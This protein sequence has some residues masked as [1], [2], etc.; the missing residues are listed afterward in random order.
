MLPCMFHGQLGSGHK[1]VT[2]SGRSDSD[3]D[4]QVRQVRQRHIQ[5][6][7]PSQAGQTATWM[8]KSGRSDSDMSSTYDQV[9]QIRQRHV[10][11]ARP[12]QAGRQRHVQHVRPSQAGQTAT[13]PAR[14]TKSGRSDSDMSCM[15]DQVRQV[16]RRHVQHVRPSQAGH[17]ATCPART[18][19]THKHCQ[20]M[21]EIEGRQGGGELPQK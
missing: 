4:D 18:T 1:S 6:V 7:R 12:S 13:C 9:R 16:R 11:H 8:T 3:I 5:Y 19:C 20:S 15:Y 21:K 2:K 14:T 10:Q 17:T